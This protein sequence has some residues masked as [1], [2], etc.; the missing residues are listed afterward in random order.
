MDDPGTVCS[1]SYPFRLGV[2]TD[3][4]EICTAEGANTCEP[5]IQVAD[6]AGGI[7]GF[8]LGFQQMSC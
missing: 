4:K 1:R 7:L 8:G 2:V 6:M 5:N 3:D